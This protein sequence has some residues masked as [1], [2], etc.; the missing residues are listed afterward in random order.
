MIVVHTYLQP[1]GRFGNEDGVGIGVGVWV[2]VGVTEGVGVGVT[3][4]TAVEKVLPIILACA[5][6]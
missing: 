3:K 1:G 5:V 4:L 6:N 2:W